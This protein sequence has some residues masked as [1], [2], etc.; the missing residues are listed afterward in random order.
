M[1]SGSGA[2]LGQALLVALAAVSAFALAFWIGGMLRADEPGAKPAP[3]TLRLELPRASAL[4]ALAP[5]AR[6]QRE[7]SAAS[8]SSSGAT[9]PATTPPPAAQNP[10]TPPP[11]P[12][13]SS[14]TQPD[15]QTGQSSF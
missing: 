15:E 10:A 7:S 9:A 12:P 2:R 14:Q 1:S 5:A 6:S 13:P 8:S 4:P 3:V 11:P